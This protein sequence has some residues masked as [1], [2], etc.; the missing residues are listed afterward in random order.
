MH[1]EKA[2]VVPTPQQRRLSELAIEALQGDARVSGRRRNQ[3]APESNHNNNHQHPP[4]TPHRTNSLRN[5]F[6]RGASDRRLNSGST[7][8]GE[9]RKVAAATTFTDEPALNRERSD[10]DLNHH[11]RTRDLRKQKSARAI[12]SRSRSSSPHAALPS[13]HNIGSSCG[14]LVP[15]LNIGSRETKKYTS[16]KTRLD[17]AAVAVQDYAAYPPTNTRPVQTKY[18]SHTMQHD[19][20]KLSRFRQGSTSSSSPETPRQDCRETLRQA[21]EIVHPNHTS[22]TTVMDQ[23][24][25]DMAQVQLDESK[26]PA[27]NN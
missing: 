7:S 5:L 9:D 4:E 23:F 19:T 25:N 18:A 21:S 11:C 24:L 6:S 15:P 22:P 16:N 20:T 17:Q 10:L 2:I 14:L 1:K 13:L 8:T 3:R 27:G 26:P 12:K